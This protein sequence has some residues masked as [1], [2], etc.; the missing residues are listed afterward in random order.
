M[1]T[2]YPIFEL[3]SLVVAIATRYWFSRCAFPYVHLEEALGQAIARFIVHR[4]G[5]DERQ[6]IFSVFC[7]A[8][9]EAAL[10]TA[11]REI[12]TTYIGEKGDPEYESLW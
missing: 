12:A 8:L 10:D 4:F 7:Y 5:H 11:A 6:R 2:D 9:K 3:L 1:D